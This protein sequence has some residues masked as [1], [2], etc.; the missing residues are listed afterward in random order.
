MECQS[1]SRLTGDLGLPLIFGKNFT[2]CWEPSYL[3]APPTIPR[4]DLKTKRV[5]QILEDMLPSCVLYFESKWENCLPFAE[6]SYNNSFQSS[7]Q[8]APFETLYGRKCRTPLN[9]P[10][11]GDGKIFVADSLREAE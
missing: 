4:L 11:T 10:E 8:I 3:L 7:L 6:F 1:K 5:N 9:W 2:K